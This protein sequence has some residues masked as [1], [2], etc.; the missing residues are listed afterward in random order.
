MIEVK[1]R[2]LGFGALGSDLEGKLCQA[3]SIV[4]YLRGS[5]KLLEMYARIPCWP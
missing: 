3:E 2:L 5:Y 1:N 4:I